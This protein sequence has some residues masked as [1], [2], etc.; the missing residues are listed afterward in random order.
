MWLVGLERTAET[1]GLA[2]VDVAQI[3]IRD[4]VGQTNG[5]IDNQKKARRQAECGRITPQPRRQSRTHSTFL[6]HSTPVVVLFGSD[7]T[8][9]FLAKTFVNRIG[10]LIQD[11][12]YDLVY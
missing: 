6:I 3:P 5:Q 12:G 2:T 1:S 11:L 10:V 4:G 8:Y 7:S 9:T